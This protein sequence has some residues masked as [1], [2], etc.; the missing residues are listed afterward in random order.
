M[1]SLST[2]LKKLTPV[3]IGDSIDE[4]ITADRIN[5]IQSS[6]LMIAKGDNIQTAGGVTK[7]SS[8]SS[9]VIQ[10]PGAPDKYKPLHEPFEV[11]ISGTPE[12]FRAGY[13]PGVYILCHLGYVITM[14]NGVIQRPV[15]SVYN[16]TTYAYDDIQDEDYGWFI[17]HSYGASD[18]YVWLEVVTDRTGAF[19]TSPTYQYSHYSPS[20]W[21]TNSSSP[22]EPIGLHGYESHQYRYILI[23][24]VVAD[25]SEPSG[26]KITQYK[27]GNVFIESN[28]DINNRLYENRHPFEVYETEGEDG[29][30]AKFYMA[31][32]TVC[33]GDEKNAA[34]TIQSGG[35]GMDPQAAIT[36]TSGQSIWLECLFATNGSFTCYLKKGTWAYNCS[37]VDAGSGSNYWYHPIAHYRASRTGLPESTPDSGEQNQPPDSGYTIAQ[38][39]NTHLVGQQQCMTDYGGTTRTAWKLVPGPGALTGTTSGAAEV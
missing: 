19:V 37:Y 21:F 15:A 18:K 8:G 7:T 1:D 22:P 10:G 20:I 28:R 17:S 31:W 29:A 35:A 38:L 25:T 12:S 9:V 3:K 2:H 27:K 36:L 33:R 26:F 13:S 6:V 39:T 4:A 23:A 24:K 34:T 14:M 5:A 11:S 30:T 32:G 16:G